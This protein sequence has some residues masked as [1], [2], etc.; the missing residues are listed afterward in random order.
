MKLKRKK[1]NNPEQN[2]ENLDF[3]RKTAVF[4]V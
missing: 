3:T 2:G 4:V 1:E